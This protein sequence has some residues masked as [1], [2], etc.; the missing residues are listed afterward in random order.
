MEY[1]D[2][3]I[4]GIEVDATLR[5]LLDYIDKVDR[6]KVG[7]LQV[8]LNTKTGKWTKKHDDLSQSYYSEDRIYYSCSECGRGNQWTSP[9][10]PHCGIKMEEFKQK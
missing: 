5:G 3:T 1:N 7:N 8:G 10:C 9:F 6:Q 4:N 2:T